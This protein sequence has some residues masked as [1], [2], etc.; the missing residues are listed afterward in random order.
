[1]NSRFCRQFTLLHLLSEIGRLIH[2]VKFEKIVW[3]HV[4]MKKITYRNV[5]LKD[6]CPCKLA[7]MLQLSQS[8]VYISI[9]LPHVI[10]GASVKGVT[11]ITVDFTQIVQVDSVRDS[12][13]FA[14]IIESIRYREPYSDSTV[15]IS[16][17]SKSDM[18][19]GPINSFRFSQNV[20]FL[21][22]MGD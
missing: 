9:M 10:V 11:S 5:F 15:S 3:S 17:I 14:T 18:C 6:W 22:N 7:M 19:L 2:K 21:S 13:L 8:I 4:R 20:H 16:F 1:M 12:T